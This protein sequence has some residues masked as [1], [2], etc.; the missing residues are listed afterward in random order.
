M[1]WLRLA[2]K[3]K[4]PLPPVNE[5]KLTD[6]CCE[7][8]GLE[9]WIRDGLRKCCATHLRTVYKN[10]YEVTVDMGELLACS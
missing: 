6:Q 4:N 9:E 1:E 7:M 2:K 10:D 5:R 3:L 8:I